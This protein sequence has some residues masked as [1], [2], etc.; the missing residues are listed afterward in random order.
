MC[1]ICGELRFEGAVDVAQLGAMR[2]RLIHRGPDAAGMHVS[3]D[4]RLGFGFRRLQIVDLTANANQ[5]MTNEDESIWLVFNGEIY[6][7]IELRRDLEGRG[8]R[9]RSRA[10]SEVIIHLY[11]EKG[12]DCVADLDG[13]FALA[14]WDERQKRLT[15]ARDRPGKKPLYYM[16]LRDRF[17]F[18]S[19]IKAFF[20]H[21][22][23][24]LEIDERALPQFF[25]HGYVPSP[26][27]F[28]QG[29]RQVPPAT[30]ITLEADGRTAARAYWRLQNPARDGEQQG[31]VT[32]RLS[33]ESAS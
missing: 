13:M 9:F 22:E 12:A 4:R 32:M 14:I 29:V 23:L 7:F 26:D 20:A 19:E 15:L 33:H 28:Y 31:A 3:P 30:V 2:D 5:P 1:G 11:E 21:P 24:R 27:T 17:V 8:H 6:N 10:D 25:L 16:R 18:A